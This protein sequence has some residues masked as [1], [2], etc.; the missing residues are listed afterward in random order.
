MDL[1]HWDL[2]D[3]FSDMDAA[4]LAAGVPPE[5]ALDPDDFARVE[6]IYTVLSDCAEN[7]N[8]IFLAWYW[9]NGNSLCGKSLG[10][11]VGEAV[12]SGRAIVSVQ[13]EAKAAALSAG[14]ERELLLDIENSDIIPHSICRENLARWFAI[15]GFKPAY[16]FARE[17]KPEEKLS[18]EPAETKPAREI[19]DDSKLKT[20]AALLAC[21]PGGKEPSAKDLEKAAQTVGVAVSDDT[22]REVIKT[23]KALHLESWSPN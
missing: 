1:S 18:G 15:K 19:R 4:C 9:G 7:A 22:I 21:W 8:H 17:S 14:D 13:L 16:S 2:Y 20:I 12:A 6:V 11:I 10:E 5:L 3:E 23:A